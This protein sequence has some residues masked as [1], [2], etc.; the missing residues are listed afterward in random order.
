MSGNHITQAQRNL[1]MKS[2]QSGLTQE[3]S[4]AKADISVRT[5]RRIEKHDF[6]INKQRHWKTRSDPFE[7]VWESELVPLL[8]VEPTLTGLTLWEYL[9]EQYPQA[10]PY[11]LLRTLQRRVK[12]WKATQ[13]PEKPVMFR[14]SMPAGQQGLSDFTHPKTSITIAGKPFK[15]MIYQF[16]L[17]YSGWRY[18]HVIQGGESYSALSEGLQNALHQLGGVPVEH[19]TDSLTAAYVNNA[20]HQQLT[21]AYEA[22]CQHYNL[23]GTTN[24]LGISHENGAIETAH[25]SLKHRLSQAIKLRGHNDFTSI[26][27]Y[28]AFINQSI[29]RLNRYSATRLQE[30]QKVLQALPDYRFMDYTECTVKVTTSS[31]ISLKR[32]L[33]TV[34]SR[35]IGV[36]LTIHLY[37][38]RLLGFVGQT[39]VL[40]LNR[41]FPEQSGG[42]ARRIDYRHVIHSLAAKPQAFRYSNFR[43]ELF[44]DDNFRQLWQLVDQQLSS[45]DACKWMVMALRIAAVQTCEL[46]LGLSLLKQAREETLPDLKQLQSQYLGRIKLPPE[47]ASAQ[48][49]D[50]NHYDSLLSGQWTH[51]SSEGETYVS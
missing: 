30:E 23:I 27:D 8:A 10:Y 22:L 24:N 48:Q 19:R 5:G 18:A 40:E 26:A 37:H 29:E 21:R 6:P 14:Q 7:S 31:T 32:G 12:H 34:P 9:D 36:N 17:A 39:P 13:G 3:T 49:H 51:P 28:Q 11:S 25:G 2:R 20:Q 44:P 45:R 38:D 46:E 41:V 35:L 16:R 1:Y 50:I 43:D 42:R 15:H 33:Y 4:A 47:N